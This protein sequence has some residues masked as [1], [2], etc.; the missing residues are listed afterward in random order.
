VPNE[1]GTH[2]H[3]K[4]RIGGT[5]AHSLLVKLLTDM[6]NTREESF[7]GL[8]P[9]PGGGGVAADKTQQVKRGNSGDHSPGAGGSGGAGAGAGSSGVGSSA[10][11][12]R[13]QKNGG[14]GEGAAAAAD[15]GAGGLG[16]EGAAS[17][18]NTDADAEAEVDE[19]EAAARKE[20]EEEELSTTRL[21]LRYGVESGVHSP[22]RHVR[23]RLYFTS[24]SHIHSLLN[25]LRYCNLEVSQH[26]AN[27]A[28]T[29]G[30]DGLCSPRHQTHSE[31]S[32]V[33]RMHPMTWSTR[34]LSISPVI[35]RVLSPPFLM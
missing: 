15:A 6:F 3:S 29:V 18:E 30:I 13:K 1:Y 27:G 34:A 10:E 16:D 11:R 31:P 21:N 12:E 32:F 19:D 25:V 14:M 2:P 35:N 5:I 4:L 20:E 17:G 22:H 23:T 26:P 28:Q 24:E 9:A 7:V 8:V 33:D